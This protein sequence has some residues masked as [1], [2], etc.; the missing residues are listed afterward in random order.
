MRTPRLAITL[1]SILLSPGPLR[2]QS[3]DAPL[4]VVQRL[5]D[6]FN[7]HDIEKCIPLYADTIVVLPDDDSIARD[8]S[9]ADVRTI[10]GKFLADNPRA[11][12][13]VSLT[14]VG[15]FVTARE[16]LINWPDGRTRNEVDVYDIRNGKVIGLWE[17]P[18]LPRSTK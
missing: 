7:R 13:K 16:Q 14:V 15:P 10:V 3:T 6:C 9:R 11:R 12:V 5:Y 17:F 18:Q 2:A 1:A 4:A 8:I